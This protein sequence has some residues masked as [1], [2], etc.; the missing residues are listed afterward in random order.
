MSKA[1]T[2]AQLGTAL[3]KMLALIAEFTTAT[4]KAVQTLDSEKPD[5]AAAVSV[6]IPTDGWTED[7]TFADYPLYYDIAAEGVT[8]ADYAT[9]TI[10]P[11]SMTA[12]ASC[13]LC[14]TNET[15]AGA[16]RLWAQSAPTEA[17]SAEYRIEPGKESA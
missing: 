4:N 8:A 1:I 3:D 13:G 12:A 2:L 7:E 16:I 11:A 10:S 17:I 6:T 15:K 14:R 9:V 5:K